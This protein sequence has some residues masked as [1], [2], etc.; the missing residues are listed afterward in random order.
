[1]AH[2]ELDAKL[3]CNDL[4]RDTMYYLLRSFGSRIIPREGEGPLAGISVQSVLSD[5]VKE[6]VVRIS[7]VFF[8]DSLLTEAGGCILQLR[9]RLRNDLSQARQ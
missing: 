6:S 1:M 8:S 5:S 2:L 7:V 3:P 4:Y 9:V